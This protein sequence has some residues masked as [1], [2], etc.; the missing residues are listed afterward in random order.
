M[1]DPPAKVQFQCALPH[2]RDYEPG[3]SGAAWPLAHREVYI[4]CLEHRG[5]SDSR[6][7]F[8][9]DREFNGPRILTEQSIPH[10]PA[11]VHRRGVEFRCAVPPLRKLSSRLSRFF[12]MFVIDYETCVFPNSSCRIWNGFSRSGRR[13]PTPFRANPKASPNDATSTGSS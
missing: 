6:I 4:C 5:Y 9:S 13:S 2:P 1:A 11:M 8:S 10:W 3:G 7:C 12:D